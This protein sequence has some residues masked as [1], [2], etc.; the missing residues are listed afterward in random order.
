MQA[1][2]RIYR[3][4]YNIK[5]KEIRKFKV[6]QDYPI[7]RAFQDCTAQKRVLIGCLGS[8]KTITCCMEVMRIIRKQKKNSLGWRTSKGAFIRHT[9]IALMETA[10]FEFMRMFSSIARLI[11]DKKIIVEIEDE[12]VYSE[13]SLYCLDKPKDTENLRSLPLTFAWINEGRSIRSFDLLGQ[14][15]GRLNRFPADNN[16]GYLLIDSNPCGHT[17]WLYTQFDRRQDEDLQVFLQPGGL[18]DE[19][20]NR[21]WLADT[22]GGDHRNYYRLRMKSMQ[23][24]EID[25]DIHGKWSFYHEGKAIYPNFKIEKCV[26]KSPVNVEPNQH[27]HWVNLSNIPEAIKYYGMNVHLF[28]GIDPGVVHSAYS[29]IFKDN[30]FRWTVLKTKEF[31][32]SDVMDIARELRQDIKDMGLERLGVR[33][34]YKYIH[35]ACDPAGSARSQLDKSAT[36]INTLAKYLETDVYRACSTNNVQRRISV[37]NTAMN[38]NRFFIHSCSEDQEH[39]KNE[40]LISALIGGYHREKLNVPGEE[41]Y[42]DEIAKNIASHITESV[43]YALLAGGEI[44]FAQDRSYARDLNGRGYFR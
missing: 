11:S 12:R 38:Q 8:G 24:H 30:D 32:D 42:S 16:K 21:A 36:F 25:R 23:Q 29:I 43:Q 6:Y 28:I 39:N 22:N 18:T 13:I 35:I 15:I 19:A 17:H 37:I 34:P 7:Q 26:I 40:N 4:N 27:K 5:E 3:K 41:R 9:K 31:T 20:E 10:V 33:N 1:K 14:L 44:E 2:N